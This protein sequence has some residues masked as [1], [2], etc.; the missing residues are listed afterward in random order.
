[1][2]S[3]YKW[4]SQI[5]VVLNGMLITQMYIMLTV[6]IDN[7]CSMTFVYTVDYITN[8]QLVFIFYI[9]ILASTSER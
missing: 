7:V 5:L 2:Q 6:T 3:N 1:M 8:K 4:I 9:F